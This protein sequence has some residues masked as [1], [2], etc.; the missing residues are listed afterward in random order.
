MEQ[1]QTGDRVRI[2]AEGFNNI[3]GTL[4]E[5]AMNGFMVEYTDPELGYTEE[6]FIELEDLE[7]VEKQL[8]QD[9]VAKARAEYE[10][11][12]RRKKKQPGRKKERRQ[13]GQEDRRRQWAY[14][15]DVDEMSPEERKAVI[16]TLRQDALVNQMTGLGSKM[17]WEDAEKKQFIGAID[18]DSL[19]YVND[20]LG[21]DAGDQLLIKIGKALH[22]EFGEDAYHISGDE[23]WVHGDNQEDVETKLFKAQ[24][25]LETET[26]EGPG[27]SLTGLGFSFGVSTEEQIADREMKAD[28]KARTKTGERAERGEQPHGVTLKEKPAEAEKEAEEEYDPAEAWAQSLVEYIDPDSVT[29]LIKG[30]SLFASWTFKMDVPADINLDNLEDKGFFNSYYR[31]DRSYTFQ[32]FWN[33]PQKPVAKLRIVDHED[34][35]ATITYT[36]DW[37]ADAKDNWPKYKQAKKGAPEH[38]NVD[39]RDG[40][41]EADENITEELKEQGNAIGRQLEMDA[42]DFRDIMQEYGS[43]FTEPDKK[44]NHNATLTKNG[45]YISQ[46]EAA[47]LLA[48]WKE[49]ARQ[50]G[51]TSKNSNRIVLSFFDLTGE[52]SKPWVEAGYDVYQFDLQN[53]DDI[54]DWS[55]EY[56]NELFGGLDNVYAILA[57][58]PCTDYTSAIN[59]DWWKKNLKGHTEASNELVQQV[60]RT[61]NYLKP[62]VWALENP[63][64]RIS[65]MTGL[66]SW[67][68]LFD[69]SN[70]GQPYTK[71]TAI[72]GRFDADNMPLANVDPVEGSK[73]AS[74]WGGSSQATKNARAETPEG[75][76]YSFFMANNA[77]DN[78][79]MAITGKYDQLNADLLRRAVEAGITEQE[80]DEAVED[81][82]WQELDYESADEQLTRLLERKGEKGR[83][84]KKQH[85][86]KKPKAEAPPVEITEEEDEKQT[87]KVTIEG[88]EAT[89]THDGN[90]PK[91]KGKL[92]S[93]TGFR[94]FAS[95]DTT[96]EDLAEGATLAEKAQNLAQQMYDKQAGYA[97]M[98]WQDQKEAKWKD[99][100]TFGGEHEIRLPQW[101][102]GKVAAVLEEAG[103]TQDG[104][105]QANTKW[106]IPEDRIK[107]KDLR[108]AL[109]P[110]HN[111]NTRFADEQQLADELR[112]SLQAAGM[113]EGFELTAQTEEQ[114]TEKEAKV[115]KAQEREAV[116][117]PEAFELEG[118]ITPI[119]QSAAQPDMFSAIDAEAHE[120]AASP[121]NG[122]TAPSKKQIEA[123][124]FAKGHPT[125]QGFK[126]AI[127]NPEN[128]WRY[129]LNTEALEEIAKGDDYT[130]D[131]VSDALEL[132]KDSTRI[133]QAFDLLT[134]ISRVQN[135]VKKAMEGSWIAKLAAHYGDLVGTIG[136]D[137]DPIDV[138]IKPGLDEV[139]AD[140]PI[141]VIDQKVKSKFDEHKVMMGFNSRVD[142][143]NAY[144]GSYEQGWDGIQ[145][146]TQT[147]PDELRAWT[148]ELKA[149]ETKRK[150]SF[151]DWTR[152]R[153]EYV[154]ATKPIHWL[155]QHA[156]RVTT[157]EG[158]QQVDTWKFNGRLPKHMV[159]ELKQIAKDIPGFRRSSGAKSE[160]FHFT[161]ENTEQVS[162]SLVFGF[163]T[164]KS[165]ANSINFQRMRYTEGADTQYAEYAGRDVTFEA[166]DPD[167]GEILEI[168]V[169]AAELL[170]DYDNRI[171]MLTRLKEICT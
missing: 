74:K 111:N 90:F 3:E 80:I 130:A 170:R 48:T 45:P 139:P 12:E 60:M 162:D 37:P 14:R 93:S 108:K 153:P 81:F 51:L 59:R 155:M 73:M 13:V 107:V 161:L 53:M 87:F 31:G 112:D 58:P 55:V 47:D 29:V 169:D 46:D 95:F 64:G 104:H 54:M 38:L 147:T 4:T 132:L 129:K 171:S 27:G 136:A 144:T 32:E 125:I 113:M 84:K 49:N 168:T 63:V 79:V 67:R 88:I 66:P 6:Q 28:K 69:P 77:A 9:R 17:A 22:K 148:E 52:W 98:V 50:Q 75:F 18:A 146:M 16:E 40:N 61:V 76:A 150:I 165:T 141:F 123:N 99:I 157:F 115:R 137:G 124:N 39:Q 158:E 85:P 160:K 164:T 10:A 21:K 109:G 114:L 83:S 57:A 116:P 72:Y 156:E 152:S 138:F 19:K 134:D 34:G 91:I 15:K 151:G 140:A 100:S 30:E 102:E 149:D 119:E 25:A 78:P 133:K 23:F 142:A 117:P 97:F 163:G 44:L 159:N 122:K 36:E 1:F 167:S 70:F 33:D 106:A 35:T 92:A 127:E 166:A 11:A 128:S 5:E 96:L 43:L 135:N 82:Y 41:I 42:N 110:I 126:T 65:T 101:H 154:L 143:K 20:N 105:Q 103:F 120:A 24:G 62:S 118:E 26:V 145:E 8:P 89:V 131:G 121:L 68:L 94:S 86:G 71:K 2:T 7:I 56:M